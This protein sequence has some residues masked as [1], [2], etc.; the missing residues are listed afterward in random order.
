MSAVVVHVVA[1]DVPEER[2]GVLGALAAEHSLVAER[3]ILHLGH[4]GLR[5][6]EDV[7]V[8]RVHVPLAHGRFGGRALRRALRKRGLLDNSRPVILHAWCPTVVE[9]C[10]PLAA[11]HRPLVVEA[12]VAA[13]AVRLARWSST[14]T[15][16]FVCSSA[17][18]RQRLLQ[19]GVAAARCA[20]IRPWIDRAALDGRRRAAVRAHLE[21]REGDTVVLALPPVARD[22]GTFTAAWAAMLMQKARPDVR[23]IVPAGGR[24][25]R[26]VR[27]LI[28]ACRCGRMV[29]YAP[30]DVTLPELL[31]A[32][33][34]AVYLPRGIAPLA[35]LAWAVAAERPLVT[36]PAAAV[37]EVTAGG[38]GVW[39]CRPDDPEDAARRM[40]QA[41]DSGP[42]DE[43]GGG[44]ETVCAE[45]CSRRR[46]IAQY[47]RVY[48]HVAAR[49]PAAAE[50]HGSP[51]Q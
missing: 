18:G 25:Q 31:V 24:E 21:L 48:E 8:A 19:H 17:A 42:A 27:R 34:L 47:R 46:L 45:W 3:V 13:D 1:A 28:E 50:P 49:R 40:L 16:S 44:A 37:E 2:V 9:W 32:A 43:K 22:T 33:D 26:R 30:A 14:G 10:R 23:L 4:G 12:D 36:T 38:A 35:S 29:R 20:L 11:G 51:A 5:L 41:L 15:L 6:P 39:R 7:E